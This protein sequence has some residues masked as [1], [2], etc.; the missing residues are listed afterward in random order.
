MQRAHVTCNR[1]SKTSEE[2]DGDDEGVEDGESASS[3]ASSTVTSADASV[4]PGFEAP[5]GRMRNE[6]ANGG[7]GHER[8]ILIR[9]AEQES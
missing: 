2:G 9:W 5:F 6:V 3:S 4:P 8:R 1:H 7:R